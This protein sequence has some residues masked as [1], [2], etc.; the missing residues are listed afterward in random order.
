MTAGRLCTPEGG[1]HIL[2]GLT[3]ARAAT[4]RVLVLVNFGFGGYR[5]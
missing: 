5:V 4:A 2:I 1:N 3:L